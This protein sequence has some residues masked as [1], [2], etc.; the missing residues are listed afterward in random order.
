MNSQLN[1]LFRNHCPKN[2]I[3]FL[4]G[5]VP[6]ALALSAFAAPEDEPLLIDFGRHD[7]GVNGDVTASPDLNGNYWNSLGTPASAVSIGTFYSG[8]VTISNNYSPVTVEVRTGNVQCNGTQN[9]GLTTP[10]AGLLGDFAIAT[11]TE[12]YFFVNGSPATSTLRLA[13]LDPSRLYKL[14][15][16]GTRNTSATDT[17]TT[18]YSVTDANGLHQVNL[19]TSG[20]GSGSA[21]HPYGNDDTI[22]ELDQLVPDASGQIDLSLTVVNGSF[23]Y[24]GILKIT[25]E[26][27]TLAFLQSPQSIEAASGTSTSLVAVVSSSLPA[28]YRWY[29]NSNLISSVTTSNLPLP[30]LSLADQGSYFVT[31]SNSDG[32]ITS[33]VANVTIGPDH[34]SGFAVLVDFGRHDGGVNGDVTTSPDLNGNYWNNFGP[35]STQVPQGWDIG[36]FV[37]ISNEPTT[38][39]V[40]VASDNFQCNGTQ[41]GGLLAPHYTLLGDF[42]IPTATEDYFFVSDG[43]AGV[44]GTLHIYGLDPNLSYKLKMFATRNTDASTTRATTYSVADI[45][46]LH[47]VTLQTSGPGSGSTNQP[48]GN[49][50]TIVSLNALTPDASGELDLNVSEA[51]GLFAYLGI[52]EITLA[53]PTPSFVFQ[54]QSMEVAPGTS[55]NLVAYAISPQPLNYQWYFQNSPIPGATTT[56]LLLPDLSNANVGSYYLVASNSLGTATSSVATVVLGPVHLPPAA[57]LID[58]SRDDGSN[59]HDTT[60]PDANGNYWNNL[61][62]TTGTIPQGQ[63]IANLVTVNNTA[64]T[65][66]LTVTSANFQNNGRNNGGLLAPHYGLLGDFAI[67][68]ATEDY[69][70]LNDGTSGITGTMAITG[71]DP[72]KKYTFSMFATRNTDAGTTRTTMYSVSDVNGLHSVNLQT[73]GPGAGS[74]NQPYGNDDTI[75]SLSNLVPDG[76]GELDLSVSEVN[77][78]FAYIGILEIIPTAESVAATPVKISGGWQLNFNVTPGYTYRVQR[79]TDLTGPWTDLGTLVGPENGAATFADTNAPDSRAFYRTVYP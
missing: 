53:D 67:G 26:T 45:N 57:V 65:I 49:D 71:L 8:L 7:G 15:L 58:F 55:T 40:T 38:I 61:G 73:S 68:S 28:D 35:S 34:I 66:G 77:G 1:K 70:F 62:T 25:P 54:P 22:V 63:S 29:F 41:N 59:G 31:A 48:Y 56:N 47:S 75:V 20:P 32:V 46:G 51:A 2:M 4:G 27:P 60:S 79:A 23:A 52:L 24:L 19:Q 37:T 5:V 6:L 76:S 17:R 21:G 16:F 36:P 14:S 12:D 33:S 74:T 9:G 72:A 64:T 44:T 13:G 42:A 39:G 11:A 43:T 18:Q 3:R 10:D 50:D 30:N 78:L 69:I